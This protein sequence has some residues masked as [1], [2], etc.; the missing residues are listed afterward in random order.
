MSHVARSSRGSYRS[1]ARL[2]RWAVVAGCAGT[3]ACGAPEPGPS[4]PPPPPPPEEEPFEDTGATSVEFVNGPEVT[5]FAGSSQ[6]LAVQ[7]SPPG[8]HV[9]RFALLGDPRDAF[10]SDGVLTTNPDG[11]AT[12]TLTVL[13]SSSGFAVRAAAARVSGLLRVVTQPSRGGTV[14]IAPNYPG[15]R[16]VSSWVA[17]YHLNTTCGELVGIPYPDG[18]APVTLPAAAEVRLSRV[19][20][21][22][23]LAV[24]IRAQRFAGGCRNLTSV[25]ANVETIVPIDVMDRP[26]QVGDLSMRM[27]FAIEASEAVNPALAELAFRAVSPLIGAA[28]DDLAALLDAM[29]ELSADPAGFEQARAER[30]FRGVLLQTLPEELP[31]AGLRNIVRAW[32]LDGL[33]ALEEPGAI[34]GRVAAV[35]EDGSTSLAL[36]SI[37]ALTPEEAGFAAQNVAT[38]SAE[39][40]DQLRI[41]TTLEWRPSPLLAAA[42][43]NAALAEDPTR[44]SIADA[45]AQ[46]FQ[47][48]EIATALA[49]AGDGGEAFPGCNGVCMLDLCQRGMAALWSRVAESNLPVVPWQISSAA[50]ATVDAEARPDRMEGVWAGSLTV[51]EPLGT[52]PIQGPFT[53]QAER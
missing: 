30:D 9:V 11:T 53:G 25:R 22:Q 50:Q 15:V 38:V 41:G 5:L 2:A 16:S 26:M 37:L 36:E 23:A 43:R 28:S 35:E 3:L 12:T 46:E 32:M 47:C 10:L 49:D 33:E 14:V 13:T 4:D 21:D 1:A 34:Q 7:V 18:T 40:N 27:S 52:T 39:T 51:G 8:E 19:P 20:A 29:S 42:A 31:G 48:P 45:M 44:T 24:V 6:A 17:S